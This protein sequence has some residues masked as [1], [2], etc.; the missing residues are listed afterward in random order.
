MY[1]AC[2]TSLGNSSHYDCRMWV[3][4]FGAIMMLTPLLPTFRHFRCAA[5]SA[6]HVSFP[7]LMCTWYLIV[8]GECSVSNG[9]GFVWCSQKQTAGHLV[10]VSSRLVEI[11]WL[12]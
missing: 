9:G 7:N 4:I 2:Q 12:D 11:P 3:V 10:L 5:C 6:H 1:A 8:L